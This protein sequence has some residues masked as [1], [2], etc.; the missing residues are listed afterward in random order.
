MTVNTHHVCVVYTLFTPVVYLHYHI[1]TYVYTRYTPY[2]HLATY[3]ICTPHN[4]ST[5]LNTPLPGW[6]H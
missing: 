5:P 4:T 1:Y 6:P 3:H 2:I